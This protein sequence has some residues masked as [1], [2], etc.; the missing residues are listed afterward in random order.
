MAPG[1][2]NDHTADG[3][4]AEISPEHV[5]VREVTSHP[6]PDLEAVTNALNAGPVRLPLLP[7]PEL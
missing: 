4:F 1:A 5:P 3:T 6:D 2:W 7:F